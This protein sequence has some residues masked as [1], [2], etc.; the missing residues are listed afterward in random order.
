MSL[1]FK[2]L[3][4]AGELFLAYLTVVGTGSRPSQRLVSPS[5]LRRVGVLDTALNLF[6]ELV[7][8]EEGIFLIVFLC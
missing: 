6:F 8:L 1:K 2:M 7:F 5:R 3:V 4:V